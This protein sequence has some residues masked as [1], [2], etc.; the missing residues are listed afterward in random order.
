MMFPFQTDFATPES[1]RRLEYD[2]AT[3]RGDVGRLE[4]ALGE[5]RAENHGLCARVAELEA[6]SMNVNELPNP[7]PWCA[8]DG[9]HGEGCPGEYHKE[10]P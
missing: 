9:R 10:T 2:L 5:V 4:R 7:C 3:L 1:V 8:M 6:C